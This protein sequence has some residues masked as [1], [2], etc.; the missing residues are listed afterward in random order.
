MLRALKR[1][2]LC[3][4]IAIAIIVAGGWYVLTQTDLVQTQA[5]NAI[6]NSGV[7][8][9][10][11]ENAIRSHESA[12]AEQLGISTEQVDAIVDDLDISDWQAVEK[13]SGL[14]ESDNLSFDYEGMSVDAT[15]YDDSEYVTVNVDGQEA[16][17]QVPESAQKYLSLISVLN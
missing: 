8:N 1:T 12:I 3:I 14:T 13:P 5:T 11:I 6:L 2:V 17:L 16:T 4:V 10:Q 15:L 9:S 7:V